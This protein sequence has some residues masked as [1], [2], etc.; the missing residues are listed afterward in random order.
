MLY[1]IFYG[2]YGF[3][4]I[5]FEAFLA[6]NLK[7]HLCDSESDPVGGCARHQVKHAILSFKLVSLES[8]ETVGPLY[9]RKRS[10]HMAC[11]Q[12]RK[13]MKRRGTATISPNYFLVRRSTPK[14]DSV[15]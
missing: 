8:V 7:G 15:R 2:N 11:I 14:I 3:T 1:L 10:Q 9:S 12:H 5:A 4:T 6:N 13:V